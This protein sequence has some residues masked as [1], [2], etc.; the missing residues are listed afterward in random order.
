MAYAVIKNWKTC[1]SSDAFC[2]SLDILILLNKYMD[3]LTPFKYKNK[4]FLVMRLMKI[5]KRPRNV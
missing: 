4:H 1:T 5:M 3:S 2:V